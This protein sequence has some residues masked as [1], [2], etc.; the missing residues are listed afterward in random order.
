[1]EVILIRKCC[2]VREEIPLSGRQLEPAVWEVVLHSFPLSLLLSTE[3]V[4]IESVFPES[5]FLKSVFLANGKTISVGGRPPFFRT[6]SYYL[7]INWT[8]RVFTQMPS[9]K[10]SQK[11]SDEIL[12]TWEGGSLILPNPYSQRDC[13]TYFFYALPNVLWKFVTSAMSCENV[14]RMQ[15]TDAVQCFYKFNYYYTTE[16]RI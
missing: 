8:S 16:H 14:W 11:K 5:L 12:S 2:D 1:M 4:F 7:S 15:C 6:F 3:S 10:P 13:R 9:G